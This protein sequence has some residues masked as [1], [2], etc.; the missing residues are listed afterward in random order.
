MPYKDPERKRQWEQEH[1]ERRNTRRKT[2]RLAARSGHASVPNAEPDPIV[3]L[4][5]RLKKR[6]PDPV[7]DQALQQHSRGVCLPSD[8]DRRFGDHE[9]WA[10]IYT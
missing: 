8:M 5:A 10:I 4:V 7:A 9:E 6:A 1:R 2:Q 3:V